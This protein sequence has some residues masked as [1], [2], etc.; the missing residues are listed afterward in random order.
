VTE[1]LTDWPLEGVH[2]QQPGRLPVRPPVPAVPVILQARQLPAVGA[3]PVQQLWHRLP[4]G[5]VVLADALPRAVPH[6]GPRV[7]RGRAAVHSDRQLRVLPA[8]HGRQCAIHAARRSDVDLEK[9]G[10]AGE[11]PAGADQ[12]RSGASDLHDSLL[13]RLRGST[14]AASQLVRLHLSRRGTDPIVSRRSRAVSD[15]GSGMGAAIL[16]QAGS[17][18]VILTARRSL[19]WVDAIIWPV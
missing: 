1:L 12:R 8:R 18:T 9:E 2:R 17:D 14:A 11:A 10:K 13:P 7:L 19:T 4:A 6:D 16:C 5:G 15:S 3:E